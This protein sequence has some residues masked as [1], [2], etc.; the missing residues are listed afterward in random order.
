MRLQ[1]IATIA[2]F[3]S[4]LSILAGCNAKADEQSAYAMVD[5]SGWSYGDT[6]HLT[7]TPPCDSIVEGRLAIAVRHT[8]TYDYSNLWLELSYGDSIVPDTVNIKLADIYGNWFGAGL[9]LSYQYVDTLEHRIDM[10]APAD[11]YVRHIMRVDRLNDI[12]QI[13]II[14]IPDGN[15]IAEQN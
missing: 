2:I 6:L 1:T 4:G 14:V 5:A 13:G 15:A 7:I 12:E 11:I 3:I 10:K 8:A 9:G